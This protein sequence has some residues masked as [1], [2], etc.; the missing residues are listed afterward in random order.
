MN[1]IF[2][3]VI[4]LTAVYFSCKKTNSSLGPGNPTSVLPTITTATIVSIASST[5]S[6][7]GNIS[8]DGGA[9]VTER[10]VCWNTSAN[11][12]ISDSHTTDGTGV[13][14]F[15]SNLTGLLPTTTYHV[16]AYATNSSGTAYGNEVIFT[17]SSTPAVL[18]TITTSSATAIT[19]TSASAGGNITSDG[20]AVITARGICWSTSINPVISGNHTSDGTGAGS[21]LSAITGL[22]PS[23]TYHIRAYATNSIGTAYGNDIMFTTQVPQGINGTLFIG[24]MDGKFYAIDAASGNTKWTFQTGQTITNSPT[25]VGNLVIFGSNDRT[26][27]AVNATTG[28]M[29]WKF[30][31]GDS[32]TGGNIE[33]APA[34][35]NGVV[36]LGCSNG[37]IYAIDTTTQTIGGI[38]YPTQKWT[39]QNGFGRV[40]GPTIANG[41]V[42]SGA[43]DGTFSAFS[44]QTGTRIWQYTL[45]DVS[46]VSNSVA[47]TTG[48]YV[49]SQHT[50]LYAFNPPTGN[51]Q[52]QK[53]LDPSFTGANFASPTVWNN[54]LY[55][56][57]PATI[58]NQIAAIDPATGTVK[59]LTEAP[60]D[61]GIITMCPAIANGYIYGT[62]NNGYVY[63]WDATSG[64]FK[65]KYNSGTGTIYTSPTVA[66]NVVYFGCYDGTVHALDATNGT[67]KWKK[68]IT[69]G[70][71]SG[72][73]IAY[74]SPCIVDLNGVVHHPGDSGEQQ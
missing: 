24:A 3:F 37:K 22:I 60:G 8:S 43:S 10:G 27:Y 42:Y 49:F 26:M 13:G 33:V 54:T 11:P 72:A 19:F 73:A 5:A 64:V 36:Y 57:A 16:R 55:I 53:T 30:Y 28:L 12:I 46:N 6:G 61:V 25:V 1:K 18:P 56:S 52:W 4:L 40:S 51:I 39:A 58:G 2:H 71:G 15:T 62:S 70:S 66:D 59:W 47:L 29:E 23:T 45:D 31:T 44:T 21:F 34:V 41:V 69:S 35:N 50:T 38:K 32:N 65:W 17:T 48:A 9:T 14:T 7:G 68:K 20:G 67:L 63:A 74:S